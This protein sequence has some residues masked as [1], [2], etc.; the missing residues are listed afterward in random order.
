M[1][2]L[3]YYFPE[4]YKALVGKD[5]KWKGEFEKEAAKERSQDHSQ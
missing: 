4:T 3:K 2:R 1:E 5:L